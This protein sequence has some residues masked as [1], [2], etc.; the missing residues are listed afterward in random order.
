MKREK[1]GESIHSKYNKNE[2]DC[3]TRDMV[4]MEEVADCRLPT[5]RASI[6]EARSTQLGVWC[7]VSTLRARAAFGGT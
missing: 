3:K 7:K 5:A 1:R 6:I 4:H 2:C